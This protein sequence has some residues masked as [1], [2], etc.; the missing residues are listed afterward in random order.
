MGRKE[1][2]MK[3]QRG[4]TIE[5]KRQVVEELLSGVSTPVQITRRHEISSGLLSH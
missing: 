5:F 3:K 2:V 4:F 1:P